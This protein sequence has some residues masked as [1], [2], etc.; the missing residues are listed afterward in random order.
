VGKGARCRER[1]AMA[2]LSARRAHAGRISN[3]FLCGH[4]GTAPWMSVGA[5]AAVR[6]GAFAHPTRHSAKVTSLV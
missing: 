5:P 4:L 1:A 2:I 3:T 6:N